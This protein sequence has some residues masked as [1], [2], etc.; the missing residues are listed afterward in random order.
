MTHSDTGGN[1]I[2]ITGIGVRLPG[3]IR[4]PEALWQLLV[5]GGTNV[6]RIPPDRLPIDELHDPG[7]RVGPGRSA[8][9]HGAFFDGDEVAE[10][11]GA[12]FGLAPREIERLDP[13]QRMLLEVAWETFE[14]AG[15]PPGP[16]HASTGVF[17]GIWT[18]EFE[19]RLFER[20]EDIDLY[21][22][23][24][25]SR[26]GA[27]GRLSH[28]LGAGGPSMTVDT[29]CSSSLLAVHLACQSLAAGECDVAL[30]G[31][32][33]LILQPHRHVAFSQA[34]M[35]SRAGR[36][37][38]GDA[39][40]D[41]FVRSEGV[42]LVV[43]KRVADVSPS[44]RVYA[45][46]QGSGTNNDGAHSESLVAPSRAAQAS[47]LAS[48]WSRAAVP[49]T[50]LG[51]IE[52]HGTGTP[53]G[54]AVEM[55][56][57]GSALATSGVATPC[58]IGSVKS[59]L[60][61]LEGASGALGLIKAALVRRHRQIPPTLHVQN[62]N[63][64]V[65]WDEQPIGLATDARTL[66]DDRPYI[67][68]TA[69]GITGSN[70][71]VVVGP[72]PV[73][74][75]PN[76][77]PAALPVLV[78]LSAQRSDSLTELAGRWSS[79]VA[80]AR[81]DPADVAHTAAQ[82]RRH[83]RHRLCLVVED[84]AGL[85]RDLDAAAAGSEPLPRGRARVE[86]G[87]AWVVPRFAGRWPDEPF[88]RAARLPAWNAIAT[89][90]AAAGVEH[91]LALF[92][93]VGALPADL[94]DPVVHWVQ[95]ALWSTHLRHH[96]LT[97]TL[98]ACIG[99]DTATIA[100]QLAGGLD[101]ATTLRRLL[102][103][104]APVPTRAGGTVPCLRADDAETLRTR[105]AEAGH[106][107]AALVEVDLGPASESAV[108]AARAET[109]DDPC[110]GPARQTAWCYTAGAV[111]DWPDIGRFTPAPTYAWHH[112][113]SWP[114][115]LGPAYRAATPGDADDPHF[116]TRLPVLAHHPDELVWVG[117]SPSDGVRE[118]LADAPRL[119]AA[120]GAAVHRHR[121]A[122]WDVVLDGIVPA[123]VPPG[124]TVRTQLAIDLDE[125]VWRL[126]LEPSPGEWQPLASGR[127]R[128]HDRIPVPGPVADL[129]ADIA[130]HRRGDWLAERIGRE[131]AIAT[132]REGAA[133]PRDLDVTA[134]RAVLRRLS[135]LYGSPVTGD[136]LAAH[137]TTASLAKRW[138]D[139]LVLPTGHVSPPDT[140]HD[141]VAA[142]A[143]RLERLLDD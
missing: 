112:V 63:P 19:S 45:T 39:A 59:N 106:D 12:F 70:V 33:N 7:D 128:L 107:P 30:A 135:G 140:V 55:G 89:T 96:G 54:D 26:Y 52:A 42:G 134:R 23:V 51:Y 20:L 28:A 31:G 119:I 68:V 24:G 109:V 25:S 64:A 48:T 10:F 87:T 98:I 141:D 118:L 2:A 133:E 27:A 15:L 76:R 99:D 57:I 80:A 43:L 58:P 97:P 94:P 138:I 136:D 101:A 56:A 83:L 103:G 17:V 102:D 40:A 73:A 50:R 44:D 105:I 92:T 37:R 113:H 36:T 49:A 47:L 32:V 21:A 18:A 122:D 81:P 93:E 143:A 82:H 8:T 16:G 35:L 3:G 121:P 1:P 66:D 120:V 62:P 88:E 11:D 69:F 95:V 9:A 139:T 130:P 60:G 29:A 75:P 79:W 111:V 132:G 53:A 126:T 84:A 4:S 91:G 41:G 123:S 6:A 46:I 5:D 117:Q 74:A 115:D 67:G 137:P 72:A 142:M 127:L 22:A 85:A 116:G 61:H 65:E 86:V 108:L 110:L 38:F 100:L 13:Q 77:E 125:S 78:P 114:G 129:L 90:I 124:T 104:S 14:D 71:H 131:V 34:G